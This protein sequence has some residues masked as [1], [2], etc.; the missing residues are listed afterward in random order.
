MPTGSKK[1]DGQRCIEL[2]PD[3]LGAER[4]QL[5]ILSS[6]QDVCLRESGLVS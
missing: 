2:T 6:D 1:M 3:F 5:V 4:K